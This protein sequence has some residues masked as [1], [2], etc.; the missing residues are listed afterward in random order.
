MIVQR[1]IEFVVKKFKV[2]DGGG[3]YYG[4]ASNSR[5]VRPVFALKEKRKRIKKCVAIDSIREF[6]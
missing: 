2:G 3:G 5:G 1:T 6:V 4:H